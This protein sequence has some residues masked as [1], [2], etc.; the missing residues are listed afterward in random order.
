MKNGKFEF[1]DRVVLDSDRYPYWEGRFGVVT[2]DQRLI[3][4]G[5]NNYL[6]NVRFEG[7]FGEASVRTEYVS[8]VAPPVAVSVP[9]PPVG[10]SPTLY[11]QGKPALR[12]LLARIALAAMEGRMGIEKK[13]YTQKVAFALLMPDLKTAGDMVAVTSEE[14]YEM[15][16]S[17]LLIDT[18]KRHAAFV[19]LA[20][21]GAL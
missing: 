21:G 17:D 9:T 4:D 19:R 18:Y 1:G 12:L 16:Y 6:I 13:A 5:E 8:L 15:A 2:G 7:V 20:Q 11:P 3:T 14:G 10:L